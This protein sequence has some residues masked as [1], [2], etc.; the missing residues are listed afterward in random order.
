MLLLPSRLSASPFLSSA[1]T[2]QAA[3]LPAQRPPHTQTPVCWCCNNR[4]L[5]QQQLLQQQVARRSS[6]AAVVGFALVH[7]A[8]TGL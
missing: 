5:L 6:S 7:V 3:H 2:R 1:T 8:Y 4:Q